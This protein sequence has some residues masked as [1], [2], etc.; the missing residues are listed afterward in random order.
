[1]DDVANW[2]FFYGIVLS[3]EALGQSLVAVVTSTLSVDT[4]R[5]AGLM[6]NGSTSHCTVTGT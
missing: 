1:M 5:Q 2:Q 6:N 3:H 4:L